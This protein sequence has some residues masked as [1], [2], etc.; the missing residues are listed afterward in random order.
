MISYFAVAGSSFTVAVV[1]TLIII[2]LR[3]ERDGL[4]RRAERSAHELERLQRSFSRFAPPELVERIIEAGSLGSGDR[5]EVTVMFTD[6][7]DFT[8]ISEK[9]DPAVVI[10][11]LNGYFGEMSR[12][13]RSHHGHVTR[14]MGDGIMSVF[15]A[16]EQNPWHALDAVEAAVGMK[17]ALLRYNER[18]RTRSF[19]ELRFGIG[20]HCGTVVAGVVGSEE[21]LEFTVMGD[22]VNVASRIE[23]LTR[24]FD[25]DILITKEV[26]GR[27]GDRFELMEMQPVHL[28][29]KSNS[30]ATWAL[31]DSDTG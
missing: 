7:R 23:G 4:R 24:Q 19:P 9:Q 1:L 3:K 16:L 20:I 28:K 10:E 31:L 26:R 12:V 6:I 21:L 13:I 30:I 8:R 5:R 22:V 18:L 29:G 11:V 27:I 17:R 14:I 2:R 15:G 25:S